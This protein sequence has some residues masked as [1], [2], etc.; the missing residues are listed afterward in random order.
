MTRRWAVPVVAC[1]A[2]LVGA[3]A[4]ASDVPAFRLEDSEI[5]ESSALVVSRSDPRLVFT[6]NDSG[7]SARVFTVDTRS[8]DTVGVTTL[9]GVENVDFEALAFAPGGR[10][11]VGDIGD[12]D[13]ERASVQVHMIDE[14]GRGDTT[15]QPRT[16]ELT[17][18]DGPRD[19]EAVLVHQG[20]ILVVSKQV[21]GGD[22]YQGPLLEEFPATATLRPIAPSPGT[23]SDATVL[24][25]GRVVLRNYTA[26]FVMAPDWDIAQTL[27]LPPTELGE[28]AA[29]PPE[30]SWFYAG[31]EGEDSP[32]Y[33]IGVPDAEQ[34][35]TQ[36]PPPVARPAEPGSV[37]GEDV[38]T[39]LVLWAGAGLL[40]AG[41]AV[42]GLRR[43]GG[44]A[45]RGRGRAG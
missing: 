44:R 9:A 31:S 15:A 32:V 5:T 1:A 19:A 38:D 2:M 24:D 41:L 30:G 36:P 33:R 16:L 45:R 14:P 11:L 7:D 6:I 12:N 18:A 8:G 20:R 43:A 4:A 22:V 10:L 37:G 27:M 25:D 39:E 26:A 42:L 21:F 34:A 35:E 28:S 40:L 17:Y 3:P 13:A 23:V 29:A